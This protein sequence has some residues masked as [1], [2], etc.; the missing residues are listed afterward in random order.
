MTPGGRCPRT[1][2]T[3]SLEDS[4]LRSDLCWNS[5]FLSWFFWKLP[6]NLDS[7][8]E[9]RPSGGAAGRLSGRFAKKWMKT[10]ASMQMLGK[11]MSISNASVRIIFAKVEV[12]ESTQSGNMVQD[13]SH[14]VHLVVELLSEELNVFH[15]NPNVRKSRA[16]LLKRCSMVSPTLPLALGEHS[17]KGGVLVSTF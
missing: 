4:K 15:P 9:V 6:F 16:G 2:T 7:G 10:Q 17:L 14:T 11:V 13:R 5:F 1:R 12:I 8:W 3:L